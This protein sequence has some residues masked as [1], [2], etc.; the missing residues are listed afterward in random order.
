MSETS[1]YSGETPLSSQTLRRAFGMFPTGVTLVTTHS[2]IGPLGMTANSF[3]SVS[4]DPPLIQWS[5]A[6]HSRRHDA[7]AQAQYFAIHILAADQIDI[8]RTF[9]KDGTAFAALNWRLD[10]NGV[11]VIAGTSA[12]FDCK[13]YATHLAGDHTLIL[14]EVLNAEASDTEQSLA[15]ARGRFAQVTQLPD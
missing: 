7:F 5:I 11:P 15:Y 12:R 1:A 8:A 9:S 6:K 10:D 14:G 4:L 13:T 2:A 3:S